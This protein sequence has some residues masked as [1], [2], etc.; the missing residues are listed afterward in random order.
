M[1]VQVWQLPLSHLNKELLCKYNLTKKHILLLRHSSS[2]SFL[3]NLWILV[4]VVLVFWVFPFC[5]VVILVWF[6]FVLLCSWL[7]CV[8]PSSRYILKVL[9]CLCVRVS[10]TSWCFSHHVEYL[11]R[12]NVFR[13]CLIVPVPVYFMS[14]SPFTPCQ[15]VLFQKNKMFLCVTPERSSL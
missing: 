7:N 15:I 8:F 2:F 14:V 5:F 3:T 13:L 10:V 6:D 1:I 11:P 12:P 9:F 4:S